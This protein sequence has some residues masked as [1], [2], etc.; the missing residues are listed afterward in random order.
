MWS[1]KIEHENEH[2]PIHLIDERLQQKMG[3]SLGCAVPLVRLLQLLPD[4]SN[5]MEAGITD[6]VWD[7]SE[8][9]A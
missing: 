4:S 8:L 9:L 1:A 7:L 6:R 5:A 2:S 3:E